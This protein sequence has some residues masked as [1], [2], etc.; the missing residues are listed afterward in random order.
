M[1]QVIIRKLERSVVLKLKRSAA[2]EGISMEEKLRRALR[3][4]A[5]NEPL[6]PKMNFKQF[7]LTVPDFGDD[8]DKERKKWKMRAI[9]LA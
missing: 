2:K 4:L 3:A 9:D 5:N 1:A 8:F 6:K 7:L